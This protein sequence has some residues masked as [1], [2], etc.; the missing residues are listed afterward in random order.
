VVPVPGPFDDRF[1][2][3]HLAVAG[4]AVSGRLRITSDVSDVLE[5]QVL[6]GFYDDRGQF[7]GT[8]RAVFHLDEGADHAEDA[9][10][11][12]E[13]EEFRILAPSRYADRV[14]AATIGVPVLV[15]E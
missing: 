12:S 7:L 10:P 11:P 15:N 8:G 2:T 9:G 5:L 4:G 3:D 1:S 6:A 13:L 14:A